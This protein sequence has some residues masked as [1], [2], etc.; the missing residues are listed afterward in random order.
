MTE[1]QGGSVETIYVGF[2]TGNDFISRAIRFIIKAP[3]SHTYVRFPAVTL[4]RDLIYQAT[5]TTVRF[6][7]GIGFRRHNRII[8]E[9]KLEVTPETKVKTLQSAIDT[10]DRP[11]SFSQFL[12]FLWVYVCQLFGKKVRNPVKD[13]RS[14]YICSELVAVVLEELGYDIDSTLDMDSMSPKDIYQFLE[15]TV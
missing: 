6:S 15:K 3:Y 11:Y 13:G 4:N 10:L 9:F 14:A 5:N 7:G 12:G 2:S 1:A 8:K